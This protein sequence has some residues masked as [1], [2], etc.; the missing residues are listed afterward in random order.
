M[1]F[2]KLSI[3]LTV[4]EQSVDLS[5]TYGTQIVWRIGWYVARHYAG[6]V[7]IFMGRST[8]DVNF[9]S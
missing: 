3:R 9:T 7:A 5:T 4:L 1:K 8:K 6:A 2:G